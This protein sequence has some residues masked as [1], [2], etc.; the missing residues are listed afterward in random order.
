MYETYQQEA[1]SFHFNWNK[2]RISFLAEMVQA[3]IKLRTTN[4]SLISQG[5]TTSAQPESTYRR[6]QRFFKDF[7]LNPHLSL[8]PGKN[9]VTLSSHLSQIAHHQYFIQYWLLHN[10][11]N[12][13]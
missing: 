2:A 7:V 11:Q 5:F 10:L 8:D 13:A 6:I 4:L 3:V 9:Q 1:L 12:L